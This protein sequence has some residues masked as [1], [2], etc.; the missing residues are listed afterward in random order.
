MHFEMTSLKENKIIDDPRLPA[1]HFWHKLTQKDFSGFSQRE[2]NNT[3]NL[4]PDQIPLVAK[5]IVHNVMELPFEDGIE[6][7][8]S[9]VY[10][11]IGV[12]DLGVFLRANESEK[13]AILR[14]YKFWG[15]DLG[16]D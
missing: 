12:C 6:Q 1:E 11:W 16:V 4:Q 13:D 15:A 2:R 3:I 10:E 14:I 8:T 9:I 7:F 5:E